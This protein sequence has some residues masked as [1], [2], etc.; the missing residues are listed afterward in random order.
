VAYVAPFLYNLIM[1]TF[2]S[3]ATRNN[4]DDKYDYE[5]FLSPL[6]LERFAKYM[7]QHRLQA[8]GKLRDSDNWQKGIS[9]ESY[10]K[11]GWRHFFSWWKAHRGYEAEDIEDS[12]CALLFNVQGYLHERLKNDKTN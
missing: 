1:R 10:A 6:V 11:S 12:L 5:G 8:D 7:H 9:L 3:G 4:D 2:K